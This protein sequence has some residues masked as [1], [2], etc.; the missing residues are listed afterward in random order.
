MFGHVGTAARGA[1]LLEHLLGAA[2]FNVAAE[3]AA[4]AAREKAEA[5]LEK[6]SAA[7]AEV[8]LN[9]VWILNKCA[10][11]QLCMLHQ[12]CGSNSIPIVCL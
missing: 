6:G 5:A 10:T 12:L 11:L 4:L 7:E 3:L 9:G 1:Q 8:L 2:E